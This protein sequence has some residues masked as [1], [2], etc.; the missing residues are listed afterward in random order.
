MNDIRQNTIPEILY[1][2]HRIEKALFED[3]YE[4]LL[5]ET[6][7]LNRKG[8]LNI[9]NIK[10]SNLIKI[11]DQ[12]VIKTIKERIKSSKSLKIHGGFSIYDE[13]IILEI[14]NVIKQISDEEENVIPQL[15]YEQKG[16]STM[17]DVKKSDSYNVSIGSVNLTGSSLTFGEIS[18]TVAN[19]INKLPDS[20]PSEKPNLKDLLRQLQSAIEEETELSDKDKVDALEQVKALAE[21]G[22]KPFKEEDKSKVR[23]AL[24]LLKFTASLLPDTA[25][26][27][28][29]I[30]KLLPIISKF[31]I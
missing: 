25:K 27:I 2:L 6:I 21:I 9:T 5:I 1:I 16:D 10:I 3:N 23:Q 31:F 20:P 11:L 30:N 22:S 4:D 12:L 24:K 28:E 7:E 17:N 26:L 15:E 19:T 18:G 8:I 29:S 13:S 14:K